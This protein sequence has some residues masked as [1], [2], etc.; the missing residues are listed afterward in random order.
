M[1]VALMP[2]KYAFSRAWLN[3]TFPGATLTPLNVLRYVQQRTNA[4]I[5]EADFLQKMEAAILQ[6]N[7]EFRGAYYDC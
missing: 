7:T 1:A 5:D 6:V 4:R 3:K 2:I